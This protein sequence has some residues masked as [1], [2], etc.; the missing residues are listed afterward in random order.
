MAAAREVLREGGEIFL[1]E[2]VF[3]GGMASLF[4]AKLWAKL[5][6]DHL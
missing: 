1:R 4:V 6:V 2:R 5:C 3:R